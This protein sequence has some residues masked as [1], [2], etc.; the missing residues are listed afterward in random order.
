MLYP[1]RRIMLY[2][3]HH[4][5]FNRLLRL[6]AGDIL[7][8]SLHRSKAVGAT[9]SRPSPPGPALDEPDDLEPCIYY[10]E[11]LLNVCRWCAN[12]TWVAMATESIGNEDQVDT[13]FL[14]QGKLRF[15]LK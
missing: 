3:A 11:T 14:V 15:W 7:G 10:F 12:D 9:D 5:V 6:I 2:M 13:N 1:A 8:F 4:H